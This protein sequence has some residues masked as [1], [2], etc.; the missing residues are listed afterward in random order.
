M[1]H[2]WDLAVL[3]HVHVLRGLWLL[4]DEG[5]GQALIFLVGEP[6]KPAPGFPFPVSLGA[7]VAPWDLQMQRRFCGST[8]EKLTS[9]KSPSPS[10]G[11]GS[12]LWCSGNESD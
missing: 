2:E 7:L 11:L 10:I 12:P 8:C 6:E 5:A 3:E 9:P 1:G 4:E